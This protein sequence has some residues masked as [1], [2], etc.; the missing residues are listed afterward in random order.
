MGEFNCGKFEVMQG[1]RE[2]V[3]REVEGNRVKVKVIYQRGEVIY[4]A[5]KIPKTKVF[6]RGGEVIHKDITSM[7]RNMQ[8]SKGGG[9]MVNR[10]QDEP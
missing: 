8:V 5:L 2:V 1:F 7:Q 3:Q 10:V 4:G 6:E 9:E